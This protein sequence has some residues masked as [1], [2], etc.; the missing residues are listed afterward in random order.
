MT[1][2]SCALN[3]W[4]WNLT[5]LEMIYDIFSSYLKRHNNCRD[6]SIQIWL[7]SIVSCIFDIILLFLYE[8][9]TYTWWIHRYSLIPILANIHCMNIYLTTL[10]RCSVAISCSGKTYC[11]KWEEIIGL[12]WANYIVIFDNLHKVK[13][14]TS[15]Y[16]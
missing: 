13:W 15:F 8:N 6:V 14:R 2:L 1:V 4:R 7:H 5:A 3:I 16:R 9:N 12:L 10:I 11:D